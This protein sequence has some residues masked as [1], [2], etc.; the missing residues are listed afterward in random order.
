MCL[1]LI[2][3]CLVSLL[4]LPLEAHDVLLQGLDDPLQLHLLPLQELN[5]VG[6]LFNLLLQAAELGEQTATAEN[7]RACERTS[8]PPHCLRI[9]GA[10]H[11]NLGLSGISQ[12]KWAMWPSG[13]EDP[14]PSLM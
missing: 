1:Y 7:P 5:V 13:Q 2:L 6:S 3:N 4:D 10:P 11:R 9:L 8:I 12:A 14:V